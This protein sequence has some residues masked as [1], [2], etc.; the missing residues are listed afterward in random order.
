M[1]V[2]ELLRRAW[3]AVESSG[4]PDGMQELAFKEAIEFLK[5]EQSGVDASASP[6]HERRSPKS[7]KSGDEGSG[8]GEVLEKLAHEAGVD[9]HEVTDVLQVTEDG[10]VQVT[11]R[12]SDLGKNTAEQ[13]RTVIVLVASARAIGM[14]EGPVVADA[15]REELQRKRCYQQNNFASTHLGPLKGFNSGGRNEIVITSQWIDE[16]KAALARIHGKPPEA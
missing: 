3:K 2:E 12:T 14:D 8:Q 13:A 15:V 9:L 6:K 4:V 7:A 10:K 11:T 5:V 16:F 1:E